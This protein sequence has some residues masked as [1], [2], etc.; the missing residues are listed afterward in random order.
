[1]PAEVTQAHATG[2]RA[3]GQ[4]RADVPAQRRLRAREQ[5]VDRPVPEGQ[6][7]HVEA[8]ERLRRLLLEGR[9]QQDERHPQL[10]RRLCQHGARSR[11]IVDDEHD[12]RYTQP[13]AR[14]PLSRPVRQPVNGRVPGTAEVRD[15][16]GRQ[17]GTGGAHADDEQPSRPVVMSHLEL[18]D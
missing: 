18:V 10:A 8:S 14:R 16:E 6:E 15:D 3:V 9:K 2:I 11:R 1:M 12:V 7:D 17:I 5:P 13:A 4:A